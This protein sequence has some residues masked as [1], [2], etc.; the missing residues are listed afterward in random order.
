VHNVSKQDYG[1]LFKERVDSN[2]CSQAWLTLQ[3]NFPG[4]YRDIPLN[5]YDP[6][7]DPNH[8]IAPEGA[9]LSNGTREECFNMVASQVR[10]GE[11]TFS[12]DRGGLPTVACGA[13]SLDNVSRTVFEDPTL[14][15]AQ[16]ND[17]VDDWKWSI[18]AL[19]VV[20]F[21]VICMAQVIY[22]QIFS[23]SVYTS[24]LRFQKELQVYTITSTSHHG[25]LSHDHHGHDPRNSQI[26]R[27]N[28]FGA[29]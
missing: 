27:W 4:S 6:Q 20:S 16:E 15:W 14:H 3:A 1:S 29:P 11:F 8:H 26:I 23:I 28:P 10:N 5:V 22:L 9:L 7:C 2:P 21:L 13:F 12:D 18:Y 25:H 19:L 24:D 17:L